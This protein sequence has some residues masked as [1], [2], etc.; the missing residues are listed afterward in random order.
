MDWHTRTREI[1]ARYF[2]PGPYAYLWINQ[3]PGCNLLTWSFTFMDFG[4]YNTVSGHACVAIN[5]SGVYMVDGK[6][7][8]S[9]EHALDTVFAGHYPRFLAEL[10]NDLQIPACQIGP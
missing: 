9:Q 1:Q 7:Q 3:V 6:V 8:I 5:A 10:Y 2:T 4:M